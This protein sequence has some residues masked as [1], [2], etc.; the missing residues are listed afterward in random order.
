VQVLFLSHIMIPILTIMNRNANCLFWFLALLHIQYGQFRCL[1]DSPGN[2]PLLF[3][4]ERCH[5]GVAEESN[6]VRAPAQPAHAQFAT[7]FKDRVRSHMCDCNTSDQV[8]A[9]GSGKRSEYRDLNGRS[10]MDSFVCAA[11]CE[12]GKLNRGIIRC[13]DCVIPGHLAHH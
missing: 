7:P 10:W 5:G 9:A 8:K 3:H 2:S 11:W 6:C 12:Q 13:A 4:R 1:E